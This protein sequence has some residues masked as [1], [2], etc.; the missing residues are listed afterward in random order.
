MNINLQNLNPRNRQ[1]GSTRLGLAFDGSRLDVVE[2]RRTNGSVE[3]TQSFSA[4]LSLDPP[5]NTASANVGA[6]SACR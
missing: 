1:P 5:T 2:V 3:I 4:T 6:P